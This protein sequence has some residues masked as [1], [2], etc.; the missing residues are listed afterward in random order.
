MQSVCQATEAGIELVIWRSTLIN[1]SIVFA[2]WSR[3]WKLN[4]QLWPMQYASYGFGT[5]CKVFCRLLQDMEVH[6]GLRDFR[7]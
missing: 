3:Y 6:Q 4:I 2:W 7:K 1:I 5:G